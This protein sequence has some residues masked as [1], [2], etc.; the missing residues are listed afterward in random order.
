MRM[1]KGEQ[2]GKPYRLA[3]PDQGILP[4]DG[5]LDLLHC[6][7]EYDSAQWQVT[8]RYHGQGIASSSWA[9]TSRDAAEAR[10]SLQY[11]IWKRKGY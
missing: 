5:A 6:R 8:E 11:D 4:E 10:F 3:K 2:H 1:Q 9:Y 7:Y